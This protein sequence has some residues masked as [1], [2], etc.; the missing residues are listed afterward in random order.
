MYQFSDDD[1]FFLACVAALCSGF[2]AGVYGYGGP[3]SLY[4]VLVALAS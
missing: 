1:G 2:V 3:H 4:T